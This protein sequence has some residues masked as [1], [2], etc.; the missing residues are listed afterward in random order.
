[1]AVQTGVAAAVVIA[2]VIGLVYTVSLQARLD[3]TER[4][5]RDKVE[6]AEA[7]GNGDTDLIVDGLLDGCTDD[8]A[9]D[10]TAD[11]PAGVQKVEICGE[12]F[13]AYVAAPGDGSGSGSGADSG[14]GGGAG[15]RVVAVT[16]FVEQQEETERLAWLSILAGLVGALAA[17]G[18]GWVVARR[19]V[20]PL[21]DALTS[22]RRFVADASHELRTPL[23][24]LLTRA[25]L[26]AR[27]P[28]TDD[29]QRD[30][31]AQL[32][33][34]ARTMSSV[35]DDMLLSAELQHR[36][37]PPEPVDLVAVVNDVRRSFAATAE[38]QRV[39]LVVDTAPGTSYAVTGI[40]SALRRAVAAL[41]DNALAHVDAGG[42]VA[43]TLDRSGGTVTVSVVDDGSG[44][45]PALAADLTQRFR[46]GSAPTSA[47]PTSAAD[48]THP[49]LGLGLALVDEIVT[50]HDGTLTITGSPGEGATVAFS[51]PAAR[52]V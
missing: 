40:T 6:N 5:V 19:A 14:E 44:L 7:Y 45:D 52:G 27:G 11:L 22:Q 16:S 8:D 33:D 38:Q 32:V 26:L 35:V 41:V 46:R 18:L 17:A 25:Q 2:V 29:D 15:G 12:P 13:V 21:G 30:E 39:D 9:R 3:A 50:A 10:A 34:D 43:L 49:R 4:K 23:A 1:M 37:P 36:R 24:I 42:T 47:A 20:R 28:A 48:G 51:L 31:L